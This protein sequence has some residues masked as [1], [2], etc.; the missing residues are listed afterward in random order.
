MRKK[1]L[2]AQIAQ[3]VEVLVDRSVLWTPERMSEEARRALGG[4]FQ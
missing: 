2:L 1:T 3:E 4:S